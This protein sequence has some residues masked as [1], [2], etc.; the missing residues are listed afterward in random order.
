M[1]ISITHQL[2]EIAASAIFGISA[3]LLY[4]FFRVVRSYF[5][6]RLVT[7]FLDFVYW[8]VCGLG[9]FLMGLSIGNGQQRIAAVMV[10]SVAAGI[11]FWAASPLTLKLLFL[12]ARLC[13]KIVCAS[14][15]PLGFLEKTFKKFCKK[16]KTFFHYS[17][18]WYKIDRKYVKTSIKPDI[19]EGDRSNEE[20]AFRYSYES[21]ADSRADLRGRIPDNY[22]REDKGGGRRT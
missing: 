8:A 4:D 15:V 12:M 6:G 10:A 16:T 9:L 3:G 13:E 21:S 20:K 7:D 18:K 5:K 1:E 2:I 22:E 11:Y 14:L 19:T 17:K